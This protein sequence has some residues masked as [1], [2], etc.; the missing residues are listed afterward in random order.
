M[1]ST[2][3][4]TTWARSPAARPSPSSTPTTTTSATCSSRTCSS[5]CGVARPKRG[6]WWRP[7]STGVI[8]NVSSGET[9]RPALRLAPYGAAKAAINHLTETL[10]V[11][12]APHGIRVMAVAPGTTLDPG[13]ARRA[14]G[15]H[16]RASRRRAP[17]RTARRPRGPRSARGRA[18]VGSGPERD[19]PARLRR[20]RRAARAQSPVD[21]MPRRGSGGGRECQHRD[22]ARG[23]L[24]VLV[25]RR[26]QFG[27]RAVEAVTLVALGGRRRAP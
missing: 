26:Q 7:A 13:G 8:V 15:R 9:T 22:L 23:L 4:S 20:Q 5:P 18:R 6:S 16:R 14:V 12:L 2:S 27:L 17:A 19:R 25:E 21:L 24:L 1:G 10:A 3:R 11:E